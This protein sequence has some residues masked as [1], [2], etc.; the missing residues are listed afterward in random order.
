MSISA[1]KILRKTGKVLLWIVASIIFLVLLVYVLVQ[2]PAVQ[3]F[4]KKKTV[5]FLEGKIK[6]KVEIG[7]LS[8]DFPKRLVLENVYFEDQR[9]DTLL[10]AQK[11][12]VDIALFK[13]LRSEVEIGYLGLDG[14]RG[15]I[16][17]TGNDTLF[18]YDYIVK[19][20]MS[21][22]EKDPAD[23]AASTMKF[24]LDKIVLNR[25]HATFKDDQT[26][27]DVDF[28]LGHFDTRIKTFDLQRSIY[29]VPDIN[30]SGIR[31]TVKQYK[32]LMTAEPVATVEAESNEPMDL[33]LRLKNINL[34]DIQFAY[35]NTVQALGTRLNLGELMA[36]VKHINLKTLLIQLNKVELN[37][38]K[39]AVA[40][41]KSEQSKMVAKEIG[42][43]TAAQANNPWKVE[44]DKLLFKNNDVQF[45]ND[46]LPRQSS[47]MDYAH[48][49]IKGLN[50]DADTLAFSPVEYKGRIAHLSMMEQSGFDL[51]K[52]V[53]DFYY[54]PKEA[55]LDNLVFQTPGSSLGNKIRISYPSVDSMATHPGEIFV[56]ADLNESRLAVKDLL[57]F[58]PTLTR[59]LPAIS[60]YRNNVLKINTNIRGHVKDLNIP[61]F[62]LSGVGNTSIALSGNIKGLPNAA[63]TTFDLKLDNFKTTRTDIESFLPKGSIPANVRLPE[64]IA[65]Q[66]AFKGN[67]GVMGGK[68]SVQTNKGTATVD[69]TFNANNKSYNATVALNNLD[70]GY[71]TKQ[72]KMLGRITLKATAKGSGFD[73]KTANAVITTTVQEAF[74]NGYNYT[75]LQ[76]NANV[77]RGNAVVKARMNDRNIAFDLST[78]ANLN[79]KF[80]AVKLDLQLDTLN[81]QRLKLLPANYR[82]K[83]HIVADLPSTNPDALV[84]TININNLVFM[85]S[86]RAIRL[87][88]VFI[89]AAANGAQ[90]TIDLQSQFATL[91]LDGQYKITEVGAA[92]QQTIN[93]YYALPGF[94]PVP[95]S[96]QAWTLA[97]KIT[98]N[99]PIATM[100]PQLKGTDTMRV[101][102]AFNSAE[103][104][105]N[106]TARAPLIVFGAQ[107]IDSLT[108]TANT[109]GAQLDYAVTMNYAGS[110]DFFVNR[111]SLT[112]NL[113][114]NI[115]NA[116]LDIRDAKQQTKYAVGLILNALPTGVK[117]SL[118]PDLVLNTEKWTAAGGNFLQYDKDGIIVNNLVISSGTESLSINS[119]SLSPTAPIE[120]KFSNFQISTL[121]RFAEQTS[122]GV[123]G[124]INGNAVV[125]NAMTTPIFTSDLAIQNL[126]YGKDTVGNINVKVDN[127]TANAYNADVR[128]TGFGND[129]QLAGK[130]YTGESR[131]DLN[132]QVNTLNLLTAKKIL[133]PE[134]LTDASGSIRGSVAIKGTVE[135][136]SAVGELRFEKAYITPT[137][138]GERF[139]FDNEA[140]VITTRDII[141]DRFTIADSSGN[142]AIIDGNIYTSDF[143]NFRFDMDMT[144]RNFRAVN[145]P[146]KSGG[147]FFGRLNLDTDLK[148]RGTVNAPSITADLKI[149]RSTDFTLITPSPDP[150]VVSREGVV[151]FVDYDSIAAGRTV[152]NP[153]DTIIS[154]ELKGIDLN[155][156]IQTDTGAMFTMIIDER[157]GDALKIQGRADL[158]AAM[159]KS[160]KISLTGDYEVTR[161]SYQLSFNFLKRRFD[162]QRGS[163]LTWTGDPTSANVNI[164]AVYI[165]RTAPIDLVQ[166]QL[167]GQSQSAVNQYKQ[168][169]PFNVLLKMNGELMKPLIT[170]DVLLPEDRI[171]QWPVVTAKLEQVR[172]DEAELNK[173][174]FAL[175]LLGRFVAENPFQSAGE[176]TSTGTMV[177]QSAAGILTDQLNKLA[178]SLVSGVDLNFGV[179]SEDD[180]STGARSTRTDLTV[181]VS[182]S[183]LND[184]LKVSVGSNFELEGPKNTNKSSNNIAGDLAIDY[185]LSKDGTYRL[186]A[187]QR[188]R[189][190][191]VIEGQVVETGVSFI[192]TLDYD[193]FKEL[194]RRPTPGERQQRKELKKVEKEAEKVEKKVE[195]QKE[196]A[197]TTRPKN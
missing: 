189:Y 152:I 44:L 154:T 12:Q 107:K 23:T 92:L 169:L 129:V 54:G 34:K 19:A 20:F 8:L 18:N 60:R 173:Q 66:G 159:D 195:E 160:G 151:R 89:T 104:L 39:I 65:A 26:G 31:A 40:L 14:V 125:R 3:N 30:I 68:L 124:T 147:T 128:I 196:I 180:Y 88:S 7:R 110:K 46:N 51:K 137:M 45:E 108:L 168:K 101:D 59:Q 71:F 181:G 27:N 174:V 78:T 157:S 187:Y 70:A 150:E 75:N 43:E 185:Q 186:R 109:N 155:A 72:E 73:M 139:Y 37:N 96:P 6:T 176:G 63:R 163:T 192:F 56:D 35:N 117:A 53:T 97:A 119:Q 80:P 140:I 74:V 133:A 191:G 162:I 11:L 69:G 4:A 83:G 182:K 148:V 146:R 42:K 138:L 2:I 145:A 77:K 17:R 114:N 81:L 158:A 136:P 5:S 38:T 50:L 49:N 149:N 82:L 116:D 55:Y 61:V 93:R 161:G 170:F 144:A 141:F 197:D 67:T 95:F 134:I 175:L 164:T 16:Y 135:R 98:P 123:G 32:P 22:E 132:L 100:F 113:A 52:L 48:L 120:V 130:Y 179:A 103:N 79:S 28:N 9:K 13:L 111:T 184:R 94:K 131:M 47:G 87:D 142:K 58:M 177:R 91:R 76:L 1:K 25:I 127:E 178:G 166:N 118:K 64:T 115:L 167:A 85:D 10:A 102:M 193:S 84:G 62:Q 21:D 29:E 33:D 15:N 86:V 36:D 106:L 112:G 183:L 122:L 172:R 165:A 57:V 105:L 188:N 24:K 126:T 153:L 41:G 156:N 194:F 190:E 171:S 143:K 90:R 99:G 121:T